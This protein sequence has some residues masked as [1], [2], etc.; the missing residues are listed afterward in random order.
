MRTAPQRENEL[1]C[2]DGN[3]LPLAWEGRVFLVALVGLV[4]GI[5]LGCI[6]AVILAASEPAF[7]GMAALGGILG[8]IAGGKLEADHWF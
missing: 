1:D 3:E 8:M 7:Y 2:H 6:L 5:Q 4:P